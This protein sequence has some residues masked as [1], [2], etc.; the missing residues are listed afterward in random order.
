M[1]PAW[2]IISAFFGRDARMP[3]LMHSSPA[4]EMVVRRRKMKRVLLSFL[5]AWVACAALPGF[6]APAHP[7]AAAGPGLGLAVGPQGQ[8]YFS[9]ALRGIWS[10]E[11]GGSPRQAQ[12]SACR[13]LALDPEGRFSRAA[14]SRFARVSPEGALPAL[15]ASVD[16]PI[17]VGYDGN[18]YYPESQGQVMQIMR[19]SPEGTTSLVAKIYSDWNGQ[20]LT[21][22]YGIAMGP[23]LNI[24]FSEDRAVRRADTEGEIR[25]QARDIQIPGCT[26]VRI[27]GWPEGPNIRGIAVDKAGTTYAAATGCRCLL[28]ISPEGA[29]TVPVVSESPWSPTAVALHDS[30]IY[31]LEADLD[32]AG[33][34][35]TRVRRIMATG[36]SATVAQSTGSSGSA[37]P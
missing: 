28:K 14:M 34:R 13:W 19:L 2:F 12:A 36:R 23:A 32:T 31:V 21:Q 4:V 10:L 7:D 24:Y 37:K 27:P 11:A 5:A 1:P 8:I 3:L 17:A 30:D 25:N 15:L 33:Q 22:I 6:A 18:L 16:C 20:P 35:T 29:I 26:P 9:D